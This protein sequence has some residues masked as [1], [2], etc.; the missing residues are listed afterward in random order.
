MNLIRLQKQEYAGCFLSDDEVLPMTTIIKS[1]SEDVIA[2]PSSLMIILDLK[3]GDEVR[4][5][6][7]DM[8]E[9]LEDEW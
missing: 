9:P 5:T 8:T 4:E 6:V 1:S 7:G 2:L 3:E